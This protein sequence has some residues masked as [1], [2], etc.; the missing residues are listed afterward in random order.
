MA[1]EASVMR[2]KTRLERYEM[3]LS[4]L[5]QQPPTIE[6]TVTPDQN[7]G[8]TIIILPD[9]KPS[10][11]INLEVSCVCGWW[12]HWDELKTTEKENQ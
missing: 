6:P 5:T 1:S 3:M 11:H 4:H 2:S 8:L 12:D 9:P 7:H 10:T